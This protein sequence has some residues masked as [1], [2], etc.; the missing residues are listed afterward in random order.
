MGLS[1]ERADSALRI[2]FCQEN[3]KED[4]DALCESI[5]KAQKRLKK[6]SKM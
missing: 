1:N 4:I 2:S 5:E 3:E 6:S